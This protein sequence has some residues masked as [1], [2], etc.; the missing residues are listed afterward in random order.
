[1]N[2]VCNSSVFSVSPC[3]KNLIQLRCDPLQGIQSLAHFWIGSEL[4]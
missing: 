3:F 2:S 1:M 4:A